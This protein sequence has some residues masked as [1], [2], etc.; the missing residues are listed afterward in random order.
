MA[1]NTSDLLKVIPNITTPIESDYTIKDEL[2]RGTFSIVKLALDKKTGKDYAVKIMDREDGNERKKEII[3]VEIEILKLCNHPN[4]VNLRSV[5]ETPDQY[6]LVLERITGGELFDKIV[7]IVHYS[8][9]DAAALI[10]QILEGVQHLH[11]KN[12]VHRDLKPENLLLSSKDDKNARVLVTDFGLSAIQKNNKP[13]KRAV[14]TPGYLAPEVLF[15]LDT[16]EGYGK[17]VDLWGIGVIMYILL[18]GFPPF[19]GDDDDEVYDKICDGEYDFPSPYWDQISDAAKDLI[20]RFLTIDPQ[21]RITTQ[22]ALEHEWIANCPANQ[23]IPK[24]NIE[25]IKKFNAR[26]RFRG[27]ILATMAMTKFTK[28]LPMI[29]RPPLAERQASKAALA[30]Q[31]DTV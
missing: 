16:D 31:K 26:R 5:Y 29:T 4:I 11:S 17:E 3:E 8:E 18:C 30:A 10:S 6:K 25:E 20:N 27:A 1:N 13:L 28:G 2:G 24:A 23:R 15:T 12:I 19:Y 14:G 21:K 9:A 7:E 22:Q